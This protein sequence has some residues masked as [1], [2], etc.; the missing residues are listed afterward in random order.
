MFTLKV[1]YVGLML[2]LYDVF[3]DPMLNYCYI[4][5]DDSLHTNI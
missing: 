5:M 1:H 2:E 4:I 3:F